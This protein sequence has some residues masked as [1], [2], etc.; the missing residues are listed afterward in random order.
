M[1]AQA[2]AA[3]HQICI[4]KDFFSVEIFWW[5]PEFSIKEIEKDRPQ[6]VAAFIM[7]DGLT[8]NCVLL[9]VNFLKQNCTC[10]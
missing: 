8:S 4:K 10:H 9:N 7:N 5:R 1:Q 6:N 2:P 3:I